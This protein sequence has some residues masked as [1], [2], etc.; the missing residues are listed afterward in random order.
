MK[1]A[2]FCLLPLVNGTQR[3]AI[4]VPIQVFVDNAKTGS[5]EYFVNSQMNELKK[6]IEMQNRMP[7]IQYRTIRTIPRQRYYYGRRRRL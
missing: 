1:S 7:Q 5:W 3:Y 2:I 4:Q 6:I